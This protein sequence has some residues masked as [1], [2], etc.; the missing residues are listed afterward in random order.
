MEP[1]FGWMA[2]TALVGGSVAIYWLLKSANQWYYVS[3]LGREQY[4]LPPGD[5]GWPL[6]GNMWSFLFA[7]KY[8]DPDSFISNMAARF[9]RTGIYKAYMFGSPSIIVT[10]PETCKQVLMDDERFKSGWPKST[11]ELM[12]RKSFLGFAGEEHKRLRRLTAAPINGHKAL[13]MYHEYIKEVTINSL[14][15]LAKTNSPIEFLIEVKKITF[16]IIMHI[17]LG[18]EVDPMMKTLEEEYVNLNNGLRAMATKLPGFAFYKALKARKKLVK[19]FQAVVDGRRARKRSNLSETQKDM[20]ELL[21]DVEENGRKLDDEEIIDIILMYL[22]A[23]HESSAHATMWAALFLQQHP[24]CLQKAKRE[25]EEIIR[26]RPSTE[27]GLIY[28]EIKQMEYLSKVIDETLR[29]VTIS[30]FT[31]REAK[32]DVSINGYTIPQGWK[33]LVWF[34]GVHMDPENYPNPKDFNPSR[35][36]E[37]KYKAGTFFPFGRGTRLCPG[38]DLAKLEIYTFLH[39]FLLDYELEPLNPGTAVTYLPHSTP[40]DNCLAKIKKLSTSSSSYKKV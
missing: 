16:K 14:D 28:K 34:R 35:W 36:E 25:Q 2:F 21:M 26:G 40:G 37:N 38:S 15:E 20:M 4:S 31:C 18:S 9:G 27:K 19:I 11:N 24:E 33:V 23:G 29:A 17:F 22:N 5:M 32:T 30:L 8:G 7:F 1:G 6:I 39:Y 13:S 12:G 10:L 3:R